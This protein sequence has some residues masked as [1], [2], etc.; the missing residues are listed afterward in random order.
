M[1]TLTIYETPDVEVI[2]VVTESGFA[3][4]VPPSDNAPDYDNGW[5]WSW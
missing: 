1:K 5:D 4:S 2:H 3:S